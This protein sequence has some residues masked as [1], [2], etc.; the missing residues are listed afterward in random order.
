MPA[1]LRF[2][3]LSWDIEL[4]LGNALTWCNN[5]LKA[6]LRE[7]IRILT[8]ERVMTSEKAFYK[9]LT[10]EARDYI[11]KVLKETV[12]DW[13]S[14]ETLTGRKRRE[15]VQ[16][17]FARTL[18]PE[19]KPITK[20]RE[21]LELCD[22]LGLGEVYDPKGDPA[23]VN[24]KFSCNDCGERFTTEAQCK[25]HEG[26][27]DC[28]CWRS[29][30]QAPKLRKS[31]LKILNELELSETTEVN[32]NDPSTGILFSIDRQPDLY[33]VVKTVR[34]NCWYLEQNIVHTQCNF[35]RK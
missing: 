34:E 29:R 11:G 4:T 2:E 23:N 18:G 27:P 5:E 10:K 31:D 35:I 19:G 6:I 33:V 7:K 28:W 1:F 32:P 25:K 24:Q 30:L 26:K 20:L 14:S 21:S 3:I 22:A 12:D 16:T 9:G 8:L 15:N 13:N 17:A